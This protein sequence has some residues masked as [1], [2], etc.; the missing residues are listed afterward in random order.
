MANVNP[1]PPAAG[2]NINNNNHNNHNIPPQEPII[3]SRSP[4]TVDNLSLTQILEDLCQYVR[5]RGDPAQIRD[6]KL[7]CAVLEEME[8]AP[9]NPARNLLPLTQAD[10]D[11]PYG[12]LGGALQEL[13]NV[14]ARHIRHGKSNTYV[15][16]FILGGVF[17]SMK[18]SIETK[19]DR[20]AFKDAVEQK[21]QEYHLGS[22]KTSKNKYDVLYKLLTKYP[23]MKDLDGS[24]TTKVSGNVGWERW[25]RVFAL[26][27]RLA[28]YWQI[29]KE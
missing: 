2:V 26:S 17:N 10:I 29:S 18:Q 6:C 22:S 19:E 16:D 7:A 9:L 8:S 21:L 27:P 4:A 1:L 23:R 20:Q 5:A 11:R 24:F 28:K 12:G 25:N 15:R 3:T 14:L 13:D